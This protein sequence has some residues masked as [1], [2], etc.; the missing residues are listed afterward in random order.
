MENVGMELERLIRRN[1]DD[2]EGANSYLACASESDC[3][4]KP[5]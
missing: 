5:L 4:N 1:T 2:D 3:F